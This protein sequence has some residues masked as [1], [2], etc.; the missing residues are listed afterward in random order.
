MVGVGQVV[1]VENDA[2]A[3]QLSRQQTKT[4]D[5]TKLEVISSTI[6]KDAQVASLLVLEAVAVVVDLNV[7]IQDAEVQEASLNVINA[8]V[9]AYATMQDAV[10]L[11]LLA[12]LVVVGVR[13]HADDKWQIKR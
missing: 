5:V 4:R 9:E 8:D 2:E 13:R 6:Q 3:V 11:G 1:H 10:V 7:H 12:P